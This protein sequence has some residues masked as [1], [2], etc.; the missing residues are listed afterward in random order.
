MPGVLRRS[1]ECNRLSARGSD[2]L[3]LQDNNL[4]DRNLKQQDV[5]LIFTRVKKPG[6]RKIKFP[7][8][9]VRGL[10]CVAC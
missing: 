7:E 8:F 4:L 9:Q 2:A 10:R 1:T 3:R 6:A 5:D